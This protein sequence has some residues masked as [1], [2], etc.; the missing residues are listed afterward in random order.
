M[1]TELVAAV[2]AA[3]ATV[4]DPE[5]HRPITE[6]DMV[7]ALSVDEAGV[8]SLTILLTITG[9][10]MANTIESDV[11]EK[12]TSVPGISGV[13][14]TMSAMNDEQRTELKRKLRGGANERDIP[15]SKADSTT[16]VILVASGKGGV[17]KS[18]VTVNLAMALANEGRSVG[19]LDADIYGHSIPQM[20]GLMESWPTSVDGMILPVPTMGLKVIS[21][22][23]MKESR[24]Q[25][26]AWR[27]P[28]LDRALQQFLADVYWGDL[29]YLIVDL[30]PGTGD[31]ALSLG[32]KLPNAEVLVVTTPQQAAAEVA[33]RAGTM[34]SM[35]DQKVLGVV[36][37]M[38]YLEV[39]CSHGETQRVAVFGTGGGAEVAATLTKRLGYDVPL[40]AEVPMD[41][42][43]SAGGDD[44]LPLVATDPTRP[45][46]QAL[47]GL[48][49][50][51]VARRPS[52][53][54][55]KLGLT[56]VS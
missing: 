10:P 52:L 14:L 24:D 30:P 27:G 41:P 44:G 51:I 36:E 16:Q 8:A 31:V 20:L 12:V 13:N 6:L 2:N 33:E 40:L 26:I 53:A 43:V 46:A 34:A 37:N 21:I 56:P 3:L 50:R 54:G 4:I 29:D 42:A 49:Q 5:I 38:A 1:S 22:G 48:A 17:G 55:R 11:R 45:A 23:M 25:V 28:I 32:Q 7:D 19:V 9:C 39:T 47:T 35:L 15:F 18:S